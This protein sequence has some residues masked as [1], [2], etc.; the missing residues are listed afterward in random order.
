MGYNY[1]LSD[2]NCALGL[3]Q[4]KK[5]R[6]FFKKRKKIFDFYIKKL[7]P[8]FS[9]LYFPAANN[10]HNLY[11]L[12]LMGINFEKVKKNKKSFINFLNKKGIFPQFHYKPIFLFSFFKNKNLK[13][14]PGSM[15]YYKNF[16]SLP[17]YYN[18]SKKDQIYIISNIIEYLKTNKK[19]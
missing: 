7:K 6:L 8:Y 10:K 19:R 1:R 18:L 15:K 11:H 5:I 9:Y 14:F 16:I 4:I 17:I 2:I 12:F 13:K 3:S